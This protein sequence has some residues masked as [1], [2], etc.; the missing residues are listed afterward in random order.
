MKVSD[1]MRQ[2]ETV[3]EDQTSESNLLAFGD[4]GVVKLIICFASRDQ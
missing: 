1:E 4:D 3:K 2:S